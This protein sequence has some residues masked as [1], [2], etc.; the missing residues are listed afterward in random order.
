MVD[1]IYFPLSLR[2]ISFKMN[3]IIKQKIMGKFKK[4]N[5]YKSKLKKTINLFFVNSVCFSPPLFGTKNKTE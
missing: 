2:K 1:M 5:I 3:K 4:S